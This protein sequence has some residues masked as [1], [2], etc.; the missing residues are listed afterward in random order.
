M[1]D[2]NNGLVSLKAQ[3]YD[4]LANI[5]ESQ[6]QLKMVNSK[7]YEILNAPKKEPTLEEN[8]DTD[9]E[10]TSEEDGASDN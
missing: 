3:A 1:S 8:K 10:T 7:I 6:E 2:N 4:L 5:Q 9:T